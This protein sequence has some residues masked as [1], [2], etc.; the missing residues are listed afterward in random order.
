MSKNASSRADIVAEWASVGPPDAPQV[1]PVTVDPSTTA[2]LVLDIQRGNCSVERRPRCVE[3]LPAVAALLRRAR[4]AGMAVVYSLTR[5]ADA[6]DIREEVRPLPDELVVK[7]GVDKF[8]GTE[9]AGILS[10]RSVET[11]IVVGTAAHGAVLHTATGAAARGLDVIV[12][13]DGLSATEPYAEQYAVWH[14]ANAPGTRRNTTLTR[15]G[16]IEIA[17][18]G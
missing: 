10:A 6:E 14:L 13:V 2:L 12:P 11:V 5:S 17:G 3:S 15:T 1:G 4:E 8:F 9:L 7:A 16:L 18:E